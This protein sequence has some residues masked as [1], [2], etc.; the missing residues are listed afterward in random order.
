MDIYIGVVC[1]E[2]DW[3]RWRFPIWDK[4]SIEDLIIQIDI[5]ICELEVD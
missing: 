5:D 4:A 3:P 1:E 2:D